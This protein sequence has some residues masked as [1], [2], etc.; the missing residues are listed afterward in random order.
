MRSPNLTEQHINKNH[1]PISTKFKA[2]LRT[3]CIPYDVPILTDIFLTKFMNKLTSHQISCYK[4]CINK[5]ID[6]AINSTVCQLRQE[7]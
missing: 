2:D 3:L 7:E 5:I 4:A 6:S 1:R